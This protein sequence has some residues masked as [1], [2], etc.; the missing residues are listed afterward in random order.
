[1]TGGAAPKR[2]G[3]AFERDVVHYF[4]THGF[5]AAER[6]YGAGRP[7]DVG[8]IGGLAGFVVE[9]KAHRSI[10]LAGFVDEAE[11]ER[12]NAGAQFGVVIAKRRNKSTGQSYVVM[13]L[14]SFARLVAS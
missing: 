2:R 10:D 8:D 7:Q 4:Q 14:E 13:D 12:A 9:V 5:P 11:I 6:T 3:S 1:M